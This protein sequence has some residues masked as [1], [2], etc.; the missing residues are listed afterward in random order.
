MNVLVVMTLGRSVGWLQL[1]SLS[2]VAFGLHTMPEEGLA[3]ISATVKSFW[4]A[5]SSSC[6]TDALRHSQGDSWGDGDSGVPL[7]ALSCS[8]W[9]AACGE[10]AAPLVQDPTIR[11]EKRQVSPD[12]EKRCDILLPVPKPS[13]ESFL[14]VIKIFIASFI[15]KP[16]SACGGL[17]H[18]SFVKRDC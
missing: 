11:I 16:R 7:E 12:A 4:C 1:A 17:V 13:L 14:N 3:G 18:R 15:G 5:P 10:L 6:P 9:T 8:T 2:R